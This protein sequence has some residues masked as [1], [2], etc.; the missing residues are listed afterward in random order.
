MTVSYNG[1]SSASFVPTS[2]VPQ[3][4]NLG[5]LLFM[6]YM[7]ELESILCNNFLLYAD[8]TEIFK[9][10]NCIN[11]CEDLQCDINKFDVW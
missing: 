6:I 3:D 5:P 9:A 8:D 2:G 10:I 7:N 4:S 11:D 1:F